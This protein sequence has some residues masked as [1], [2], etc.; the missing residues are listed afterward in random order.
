[1]LNS[2]TI[3]T[4]AT[5]K[6]RL[7]FGAGLFSALILANS[8]AALA[9]TSSGQELDEQFRVITTAVPI[10]T[11]APDAR[12]AAMG[13]AGVAISP[14]A[15]AA[16]WNP[17]KLGNMPKDYGFAV[18]YTPWLRKLIN[19]MSLSYVTGYKRLG[20]DRAL[21]LSLMYFSLGDIKFTDDRGVEITEFNPKEYA[22]SLAYGQ[23]LSEYLSL[24]IGARYIRSNLSGNISA[25]ATPVRPGNSAAADLG[26]FYSRGLTVSA[27]DANLSFGAAVTNI[28]PKI[29][30]T[31]N[32]SLNFLPTNLR[33]GAAF[34]YELDPFNKITLTVDANKL[35]VP[36]PPVR[37]LTT[38]TIIAGQDQDRPLLDA[39]FT[40]FNDAPGGSKEELQEVNLSAGFEYWYNDLFAA[41]AGYFHENP[42]KG[43]RQYYSMGLGL[44]YQVLGVDIAYLIPSQQNNPLAETLRFTLSFGFD[45]ADPE[46]PVLE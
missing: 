1:M 44:R 14:D 45:K 41:R 38:G 19:D 22:I 6:S 40:S 34:T 5:S 28:G 36:T 26:I 21:S 4:S 23:K 8:P 39:M 35:L 17:A 12:S 7:F 15:N 3:L 13:D 2:T 18:S 29:T 24:G 37:D 32:D 33:L 27:H 43:N 9:Q 46:E 20:T 16:H 11:V 10:L 31:E 30:Y 25:N 42:L